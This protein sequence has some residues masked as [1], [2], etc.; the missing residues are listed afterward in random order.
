MNLALAIRCRVSENPL[1]INSS[2]DDRVMWSSQEDGRC[3]SM[4]TTP[5]GE[6]GKNWGTDA[7][8][9]VIDGNT[10]FF[11]YYHPRGRGY[12]V[13]LNNNGELSLW[14]Y[15]GSYRITPMIEADLYG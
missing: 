6:F 12:V 3:I 9:V 13:L 4:N 7:D 8:E 5:R 2:Y 11:I 15:G 1:Y 10:T 14:R